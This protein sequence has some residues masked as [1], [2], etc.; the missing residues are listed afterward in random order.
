MKKDRTTGTLTNS[1]VSED[2]DVSGVLTSKPSKFLWITYDC[3]SGS[4]YITASNSAMNNINTFLDASKCN[5]DISSS[6]ASDAKWFMVADGA[7]IPMAI[8]EIFARF[9]G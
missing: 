7:P 2:A 3:G 1:V 9:D 5:F 4:N 8:N 6:E